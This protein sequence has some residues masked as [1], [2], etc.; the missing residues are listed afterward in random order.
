[1]SDETGR[2]AEELRLL[3]DAAAERVQPWLQKVAE[4]GDP[5]AH[6]PETCGWC[7]LCNGVALLRGD[8]SELASKAAEHAAGLIAVLRAALRE[9]GTPPPE[10]P[11]SSGSS[12]PRV[13]HIPVVRRSGPC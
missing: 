10:P 4:A 11:P 3:I 13:Q 12:E 5:E 9:P 6:T 1:M 8:R 7:P 2:L